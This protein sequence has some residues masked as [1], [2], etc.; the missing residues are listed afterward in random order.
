VASKRVVVLVAAAGVL[1][2]CLAAALVL[3]GACTDVTFGSE[4]PSC[5]G[6]PAPWWALVLAGGLGGIVASVASVAVRR[7][8]G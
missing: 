5:E 8:R 1:V 6:S 2:G 4:T 7:R 3:G